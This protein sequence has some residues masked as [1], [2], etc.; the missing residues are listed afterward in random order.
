MT[1]RRVLTRAAN[2][3]TSM[4][5]DGPREPTSLAAGRGRLALLLD[6]VIGDPQRVRVRLASNEVAAVDDDRRR[7]GYPNARHVVR[8]S[9]YLQVHGKAAHRG[10]KLF[11]VDAVVGVEGR[12]FFFIGPLTFGGQRTVTVNCLVHRGVRFLR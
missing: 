1:M 2:R 11:L 5:Y 7:A 9:A 3:V 4:R 12:N 8:R 6:Q 10:Q